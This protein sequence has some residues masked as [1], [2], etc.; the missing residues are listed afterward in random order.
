MIYEHKSYRSFL[1]EVLADRTN[2]NPKYSLRAMAKNLGF[3]SSSLSEVMTGKSG[4][5]LP[6]ARK[7]AAKLELSSEETEYLCLLVQLESSE[8]PEIRESLLTRLTSLMPKKLMIHDLGVDHFRQISEWYHSAILE[9]AELYHFELS[10]IKVAKRLGISKIEAEVAIERMF[11][12][13]LLKK[14]KKEKSFALKSIY[15]FNPVPLIIRL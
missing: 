4:F 3:A 14:I 11:R 1:R 9:M 10:P 13:G 7:I 12:L 5:S 8:D 6:S 2:K 15:L